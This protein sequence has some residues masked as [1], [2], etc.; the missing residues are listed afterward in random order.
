MH[1]SKCQDG[2]EEIMTRYMGIK[3]IV[4]RS[5]TEMREMSLGTRGKLVHV[6]KWQRTWLNYS[7]GHCG[8]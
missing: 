8:R 4:V 3:G 6:I 1:V 7:L 5:R 2:L